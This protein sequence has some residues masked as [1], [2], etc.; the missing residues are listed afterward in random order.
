[1][2]IALAILGY[3]VLGLIQTCSIVYWT[4]LLDD[5]SDDN[6]CRVMAMVCW[7]LMNL[8]ILLQVPLHVINY[9]SDKGAERS[10]RHRVQLKEEQLRQAQVAKELAMLEKELGITPATVPSVTVSHTYSTARW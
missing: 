6:F 5:T 10:E 9:V 3:F 7:P 2:L 4:D 1:M 8:L